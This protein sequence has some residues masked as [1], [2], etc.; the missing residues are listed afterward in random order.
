MQVNDN[1]SIITAAGRNVVAN[2]MLLGGLRGEVSALTEKAVQ[3][4]AQTRNG[5]TVTAWFPRKALNVLRESNLAG[6]NE[7]HVV[8][9]MAAWFRP[10]GWTAKFMAM[11]EGVM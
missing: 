9:E 8:A 4:V 1:I 2:T 10:D 7:T 5:K 3:I 6:S 11:T